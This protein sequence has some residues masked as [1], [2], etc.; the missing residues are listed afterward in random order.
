LWP[1][2]SVP[3]AE[4]GARPE[5]AGPTGSG[6]KAAD[7]RDGPPAHPPALTL[8]RTWAAVAAVEIVCRRAG[9]RERNLVAAPEVPCHDAEAQAQQIPV[10][11]ITT[12]GRV[13]FPQDSGRGGFNAALKD[14][15]LGGVSEA[16][17]SRDSWDAGRGEPSYPERSAGVQEHCAVVVE[18]SRRC[19][20]WRRFR[21]HTGTTPAEHLAAATAGTAAWLSGNRMAARVCFSATEPAIAEVTSMGGAGLEPAASCASSRR[22]LF[23]RRSRDR[24]L[25]PLS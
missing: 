1:F 6:Q 7:G 10:V 12:M 8:L 25:T 14:S 11:A 4:D 3:S 9:S 2:H 23:C 18:G 13:I 20:C 19:R 17:L 24:S 22:C 16:E 15:A 21:D 5:P